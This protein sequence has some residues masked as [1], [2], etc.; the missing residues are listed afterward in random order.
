MRQI[1][2]PSTIQRLTE[3][4]QN[5]LASAGFS[6]LLVALSGG[7]DSGT[8]LALAAAASGPESIHVL[9]MP[10]KDWQQAGQRRARLLIQELQIPPSQSLEIDIAPLSERFFTALGLGAGQG[11][12][13]AS[14]P[15]L[16]RI[17]AGNI[18]ARVRM[19]LL[20]DQAR[21]LNALVLGTENKSEHLLGY[22]T[23]FGD[24]AS[25]IEPLR[26]L[27]KTEVYQLA[28]HLK[29][30]REILDARPSAGLWP[31]Q[32]D[33]GQFGFTYEEADR[34]LHGLYE[35]GLSAEELAEG[36]LK[37]E[38]IQK[39]QAWVESVEFKHHLPYLA[40]DPVIVAA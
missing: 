1:D 9:M 16:D 34:I 28:E 20:F 40:P 7:V 38:A 5:T 12:P 30:P 19:V 8:A 3:F 21:R 26:N 18:M 32:T 24:E 22:Y 29:L 25:D 36:G 4:I 27:Y 15:E 39:V 35:A 2:V 6:R 33:E 31:G 17:R 13:G 23:R 37:R 10:Y 11:A 14:V